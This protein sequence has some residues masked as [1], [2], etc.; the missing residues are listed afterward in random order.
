MGI[1]QLRLERRLPIKDG[2]ITDKAAQAGREA[3]AATVQ[4]SWKEKKKKKKGLTLK[5]DKMGAGG[6]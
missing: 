4:D 3:A 2:V 6:G 5:D 1:R